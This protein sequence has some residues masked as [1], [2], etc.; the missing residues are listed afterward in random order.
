[1]KTFILVMILLSSTWAV[2]VI[3]GG[4]VPEIN[5]VIGVGLTSL[6]FGTAGDKVQCADLFVNS[7][8]EGWEVKIQCNNNG[9]F[10]DQDGN[11]ITPTA[12]D[13]VPG[14]KN[15]ILGTG[16]KSLTTRSLLNGQLV[17]W[18]NKQSTATQ[19]YNLAIVASWNQPNTTAGLYVQTITATIVA[20]Y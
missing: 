2:D 6:D 10:K 5:N 20:T 7:N 17:S 3:C 19:M 14:K 9:L 11:A 15:G 4:R 12:L 18:N 13:V 8:T 16:A 1:M